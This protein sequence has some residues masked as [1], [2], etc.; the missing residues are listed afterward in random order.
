MGLSASVGWRDGALHLRAPSG[1]ACGP[2]R[3]IVFD[4]GGTLDADGEAWS[5][6]FRALWE[7]LG[8]HPDDATAARALEAGERAVLD[9]PRAAKLDTAAMARLH[10]DAQLEVLG[11]ARAELRARLAA[12]FGEETLATLRGRRPLLQALARRLPLAVVSNGCGNSGVLVAEAGLADLFRAVVDSSEVGFWKPDPR[13]LEP[14]RRVLG[15]AAAEVAVVGDRVDRDGEAARAAGMRSVWVSGP[16]GIAEDDPRLAQ[17][18]AV[19]ETVEALHPEAH[20]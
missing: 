5:S 7:A 8:L 20:A 19:I 14:A 15:V 9:H 12:R 2:L 3:A 18:D 17:V 10:A 11:G 1:A 13:I 16:D 4:L 6:R